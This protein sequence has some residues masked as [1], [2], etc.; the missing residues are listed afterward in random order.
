M[1][2]FLRR[3]SRPRGRG[4]LAWAVLFS[5]QSF[6]AMAWYKAPD[7]HAIF[8]VYL[9]MT[10]LWAPI[11]LIEVV[12]RLKDLG[13]NR[14]LALAY[15]L[16]WIVF[17]WASSRMSI[18]VSFVTLGVAIAVQLP[19]MLIPGQTS[20]IDGKQAEHRHSCPAP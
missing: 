16:P 14:W 11:W 15:I 18:Q 10:I 17:F 8:V 6:S 19:L 1:S 9:V 20:A 3:L 4:N 2:K 13:W 12:G 5:T 7:P